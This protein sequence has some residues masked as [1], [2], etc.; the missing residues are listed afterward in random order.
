MIG[1]N[2]D[3]NDGSQALMV[4]ETNKYAITAYSPFPF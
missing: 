1:G 3:D 4:Q 2:G